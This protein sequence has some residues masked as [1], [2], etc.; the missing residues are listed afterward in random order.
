[1]HTILIRLERCLSIMLLSQTEK[2]IHLRSR[3]QRRGMVTIL[4]HSEPPVLAT[5]K[6]HVRAVRLLTTTVPE[7][8]SV[9]HY[10]ESSNRRSFSKTYLETSVTQKCLLPTVVSK[11]LTDNYHSKIA[12][13]QS[14]FQKYLLITIVLNI[15]VSI[16]L[17]TNKEEEEEKKNFTYHTRNKGLFSLEQTPKLYDKASTRTDFHTRCRFFATTDWWAA[18][19]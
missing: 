12:C 14:S 8:L 13:W 10:P 3:R 19:R 4:Y 5:L 11:W 9:N 17:V 1:M 6:R 16:C 2:V 15:T 7:T 18:N